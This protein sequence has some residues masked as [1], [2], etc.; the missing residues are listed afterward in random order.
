MFCTGERE[1]RLEEA[2]KS[3]GRDLAKLVLKEASK[4]VNN[5][6]IKEELSEGVSNIQLLEDVVKLAVDA[7]KLIHVDHESIKR[8]VQVILEEAIKEAALVIVKETVE[9]VIKEEAKL[10]L[11]HLRKKIDHPSSSEGANHWI[12]KHV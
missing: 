8:T 3:V 7:V 5:K 2:A 9:L 10:L 12:D 11:Q 1:R 4:L 6:G